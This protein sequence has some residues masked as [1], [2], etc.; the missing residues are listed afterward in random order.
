[1]TK[2]IIHF[3]FDFLCSFMATFDPKDKS[4]CDSDLDEDVPSVVFIDQPNQAQFAHQDDD[5]VDS[6]HFIWK[7]TLF[8]VGILIDLSCTAL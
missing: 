1:M 3:L 5:A 2:V 4:H 7:V 6:G 8:F